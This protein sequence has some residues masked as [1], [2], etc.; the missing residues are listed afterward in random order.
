MRYIFRDIWTRL[1][2]WGSD[3]WEWTRDKLP[4]WGFPMMFIMLGLIFLCVQIAVADKGPPKAKHEWKAEWN[5]TAQAE[6]SPPVVAESTAPA[7]ANFT[8]PELNQPSAGATAAA[9]SEPS[10]AGLSNGS[11]VPGQDAVFVWKC[12]GRAHG[13]GLCMDG[14]RYRAEAG[15][16]AM[17][18][19]NAYYTGVNVTQVDDTRPI[20]VRGRDG[21]VR[22]LSLHDYLCRLAEEPEDYPPEGLKVL[23]LAARAYTLSVIARGKHASAGYDI[24]S[25]GDCCQAF[26]ENKNLNAS[27]NNVAAVN[28]TGGQA[29][30][31][32]GA[33]IIAAYCGSCGGHTDNN[34]DVWGGQAIPYLRGKV[35]GYCSR[36]P[37]YQA[38]KEMSVREFAS[39]FGVGQLKMVDLSDRTPG[40]RVKSV[41]ISGT[42]GTKSITGKQLADMMG[43]RGARI[44]YAFR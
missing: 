13:V 19:I 34:E 31:Y 12:Y 3:A 6:E 8:F 5:Q 33:P 9:P 10:V 20:R 24:C 11:A 36:S 39:R 14:V 32:N 4:V 26:D 35:D 28:A 17:Q 2:D 40:G 21:T 25:S 18:I 42:G 37:R 38:N 29:L 7:S 30:Y 27:P 15:Q 43:F 41:K 23:Y 1:G 22:T 44:E 16:T